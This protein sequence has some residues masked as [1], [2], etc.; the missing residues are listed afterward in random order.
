MSFLARVRF[1]PALVRAVWVAVVALLGSFGVNASADLPDWGEALL[2][3]A[4]V[5]LPLVQ[6]FATRA[7][8]VPVAKLGRHAAPDA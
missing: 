1:E 7:V 3:A 2:S 8:V 4:A 6:G 5:I